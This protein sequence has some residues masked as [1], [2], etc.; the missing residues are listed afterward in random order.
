MS[1]LTGDESDQGY[2]EILMKRKS[3]DFC[4]WNVA[5]SKGPWF[6]EMEYEENITMKAKIS[7]WPNVF[8]HKKNSVSSLKSLWREQ[9]VPSYYEVTVSP[10]SF[11]LN[12]LQG[13]VVYLRV[14][15]FKD[16]KLLPRM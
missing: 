1:E 7:I 3:D 8:Y 15:L 5:S 16:Q 4:N 14:T 2:S 11:I 9:N 6:F 10:L 12:P 13:M